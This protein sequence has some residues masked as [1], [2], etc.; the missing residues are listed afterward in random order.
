MKTINQ[1]LNSRILLF[2][3]SILTLATPSI[4]A[5]HKKVTQSLFSRIIQDQK[6]YLFPSP[7]SYDLTLTDQRIHGQG[8][9]FD[10]LALSAMGIKNNQ[11]PTALLAMEQRERDELRL[12]E[13]VVKQ[14]RALTS[15]GFTSLMQQLPAITDIA[16]IKKRQEIIRLLVDDNNLYEG[17]ADLLKKIHGNELEILSYWIPKIPLQSASKDFYWHLWFSDSIKPIGFINKYLNDHRIGLELGAGTAH[18][19]SL[20]SLAFAI[21]GQNFG[22]KIME[23]ML[24]GPTENI[25]LDKLCYNKLKETFKGHI[26]WKSSWFSEF[27]EEQY[28]KVANSKPD[29]TRPDTKGIF[30]EAQKIFYKAEL[31]KAVTFY[32][33]WFLATAGK[34]S[35]QSVDE[36][37][38]IKIA[39]FDGIPYLQRLKIPLSLFSDYGTADI[40]N[41][42]DIS[43]WNNGSMLVALAII[44]IYDD[45]QLISSIK[46]SIASVRNTSAS[47][48]ALHQHLK[49]IKSLLNDAERLGRLIKDKNNL[50]ALR[51]KQSL[52]IKNNPNNSAEFK[53]LL[54]ELA[55]TTFDQECSTWF[56]SRGRVLRVHDLL[57][58]TKNELSACLRAIGEIDAF[59]S[60]ATMIKSS[61]NSTT[62][63]TFVELEQSDKPLAIFNN[64]WCPLIASNEIVSNDLDFGADD[65]ANKILLTGPNGGGK[66]AIIKSLGISTFC[67]QSWGV[68][69]ASYGRMTPFDELATCFHSNENIMEGNSTFMAG[70]KDMLH[71]TERVQKSVANN[72]KM[73]LLVDEPYLG[74]IDGITGRRV[75]A[76]GQQ[77][78]TMPSVMAI[79][80]T[81]TEKPTL[82]ESETNGIFAN[83]HIGITHDERGFALTYKLQRGLC[84]WW[85]HDEDKQD[86][87]VDWLTPID[88]KPM[89]IKNNSSHVQ[90]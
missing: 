20:L 85:L 78:A 83:Y 81:H 15:F 40:K 55:T 29:M 35:F 64:C 75:H 62:P 44:Q 36:P 3:V 47:I 57:K 54:K 70:K 79:I 4:N 8:S 6:E 12:K 33:R 21:T 72:K 48:T 14:E 71:V 74:T 89:L 27:D 16:E 53:E 17:I 82:L 25:E 77:V 60:I 52:N 38:A 5:Q 37:P 65:S 49:N 58:K 80:A 30:Y 68:V 26:F 59:L 41:D 18:I 45:Y 43:T 90:S 88:A 32:D 10:R 73:L 24:L 61:T 22:R 39:R 46:S 63:W 31:A 66:S 9:H 13:M 34:K 19:S 1:S 87:F 11:N 56:Y 42:A 2:L 67:A 76:F 69:P 28:R 7:P 86:N 23:A 50:L 51:Y 84:E